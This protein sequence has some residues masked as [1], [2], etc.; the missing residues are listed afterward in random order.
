MDNIKKIP[1]WLG[2]ASTV[3]MLIAA[4]VGGFMHIGALEQKI[5]DQSVRISQNHTTITS[6]TE[7]LI[8]NRI[9]CGQEE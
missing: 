5:E 2:V 4:V 9:S 8:T 3:V 7:G 6:L 1:V